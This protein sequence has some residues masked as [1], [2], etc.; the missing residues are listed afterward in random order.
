MKNNLAFILL[1]IL[2]ICGC[3]SGPTLRLQDIQPKRV[4]PMTRSEAFET[5][6][7]FAIR[8]GFRLDSKEEETGR[9]VGHA[10]LQ[11]KP[12][13]EEGKVVIMHLRIHEVDPEHTEVNPRFTFS[14]VGDALTRE[15]ENILVDFY[16]NLYG[17]LEE[18]S[19]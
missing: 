13:V 8:E 18:K 15:E 7:A 10:T 11:A 12:S 6:R 5:V 9:I 2:I 19:R 1:P 14:S 3:S 17:C 4:F 16:L